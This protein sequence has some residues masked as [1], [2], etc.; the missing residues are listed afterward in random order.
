MPRTQQTVPAT[1]AVLKWAREVSGYSLGQAARLLGVSE[2]GLA[3]IEA[4][5]EGPSNAVFRKMLAIYQQ[6]ESVLLL[7]EP[8]EV[9]PLPQD[10]RTAGPVTRP[11]SPEARLAIRDARRIQRWV[12]ELRDE[13][14]ELIQYPDITEASVNDDTEGVASEERARFGISVETQRRW[15]PGDDSFRR[16]RALVQRRGILVILKKMP[17]A[18]CR[19]LSFWAP[20][21]VP[22]IVVNTEDVANARIFTLF[23]EYGHLMLR[24][25][26]VC[27][28]ERMPATPKGLIEDWCNSFAAEFLVP[29]RHLLAAVEARFP[30]LGPDAW[31]I[32]DIGKLAT[33]FRVSRYVVA[34]RLKEASKSTFYD[35]HHDELR[36][37]DRKPE[38]ESAGLQRPVGWQVTQKLAEIGSAAAVVVDALH[39][40][41]VDPM[42]AADIL[43]VHVDQLREVE[44]RVEAERDPSA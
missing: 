42:E 5:Q 27:L 26:G 43:G 17:W 35:R 25:A 34:R 1:G 7:P 23:H 8:P 20:R 33:H 11:L 38:R 32:D 31:T 9:E 13:D 41:I 39:G 29:T 6:V 21:E 22:A 12:S 3:E 24:Q 30:N 36:R 28:A 18:D 10:F 40:Q 19:G 37:Y 44:Q 15:K 4:G 16:W 2:A 14:P